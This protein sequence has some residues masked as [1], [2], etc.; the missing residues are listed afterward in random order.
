MPYMYPFTF[1]CLGV[2]GPIPAVTKRETLARL[3]VN[4][5]GHAE[6]TDPEEAHADNRLQKVKKFHKEWPQAGI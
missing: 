1:M 2:P 6:F 5:L 4:N 3:S